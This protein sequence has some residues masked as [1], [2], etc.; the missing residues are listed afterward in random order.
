MGRH[1]PRIDRRIE[2]FVRAYWDT[3]LREDVP[4]ALARS[5]LREQQIEEPVRRFLIDVVRQDAVTAQE[6]GDLCNVTVH[7]TADVRR[8]A[9]HF[10]DWLFDEEPL[11]GVQSSRGPPG[12]PQT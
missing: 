2:H 7:T 6:W 11:P 1:I 3:D 4:S 9:T 5:S 12:P 10:W 8:D